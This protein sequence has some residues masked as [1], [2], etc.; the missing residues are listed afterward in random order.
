M[1]TLLRYL[2]NGRRVSRTAEALQALEQ[3]AASGNE[4]DISALRSAVTSRAP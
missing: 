3:V 2:L 1:R 4:A